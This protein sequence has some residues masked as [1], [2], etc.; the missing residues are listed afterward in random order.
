MRLKDVELKSYLGSDGAQ[1]LLYDE[2]IHGFFQCFELHILHVGISL[3]LL[4]LS[5]HGLDREILTIEKL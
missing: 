2:C 1:I 4:D 5:P 3:E